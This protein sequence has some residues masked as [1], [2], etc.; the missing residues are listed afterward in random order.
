MDQEDAT[1]TQDAGESLSEHHAE[2]TG[3]QVYD[4][5]SPN[6]LSKEQIRRIEYLHNTF[7]KR[8][9]M[10]LAALLRGSV[11]VSIKSVEEADYSVFIESIP[12]PGATFTFAAEPLEGFGIIDIDVN[13]AF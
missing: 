10:S 5:S 12:S 7:V 4:F 6:R 3:V 2:V 11:R 1:A 13:L 8:A 9:S